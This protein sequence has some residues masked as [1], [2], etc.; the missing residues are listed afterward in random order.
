MSNNQKS[1][2]GQLLID[3]GLVTAAQLDSA[4]K[5]QLTSSKRLGEIF[6]EQGV[7]TERQLSKAL[8]KQNS[9]R[10]TATLVAA[11]LSPFQMAS[12][13]MQ[14]QTPP[15]MTSQLQTPRGMQALSDAEMSS[16]S[17][18]GLNDVLQGIFA[19]AGS[20][21]GVGTV[22]QLAKLVLPVLNSLEAE[23]SMHDVQYDTS[24]MTSIINADGSI[25]VRLP[26][27]I[28]ELRFDNI[29]VA[30]ANP[31]QSF[32]SVVM[33]DIDLSQAS[34]RISLH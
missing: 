18:Q 33:Q 30:G 9:L 7:L 11:L 24:K 34:L 6:I 13:D 4:I 31:G 19:K 12:A 10:L 5:L 26:S 15:S 1:R 29:R 8:K 28:G 16:V 20:D 14:R 2:L 25:N 21:D 23:T 22:G 17:A 3:K 32:G 27:S